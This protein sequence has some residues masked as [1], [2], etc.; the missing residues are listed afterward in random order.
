M[1]LLRVLSGR[2]AGA[3][4]R[5]TES[6]YRIAADAQADI[7]IFDW[8]REPLL[9]RLQEDG[10]I[11]MTTLPEKEGLAE[12]APERLEDFQPRKFGKV[13]LCAGPFGREWPSDV[14]LLRR[15][16]RQQAPKAPAPPAAATR[17][18]AVALTGA[19]LA[20]AA[21]ALFT[22]ASWS[23]QAHPPP[24][25]PAEPLLVRVTKAVAPLSL[26]DIV[27]SP[28]G[29]QVVVEGLVDSTAD[30]ALLRQTLGPFPPAQVMHRYAVAPDITQSIVD[31]LAAPELSVSYQGAGRF[32][33]RGETLN[34]DKV[35]DATA[36]IAADLAP[37]VRGIDVDATRLPAPERVPVN[38][39]LSAKGLQY[40]QTRDGAKHLSLLPNATERPSTPVDFPK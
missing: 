21:S 27:V 19:A 26:N 16:M 36:R 6:T 23:K 34:L 22:V 30:L 20:I 40:V 18:T 7:Q 17:R 2:H 10:A 28:A 15:L 24:Q 39:M 11:H 31:A 35:R 13:V 5:L 33:V 38:A 32:A 8:T 25:A 12:Q 3:Q 14:T 4:I 1:K 29:S 37:V 9:L